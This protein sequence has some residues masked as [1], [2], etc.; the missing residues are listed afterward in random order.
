VLAL[1][2][3]IALVTGGSAGIGLASAQAL[4]ELGCSVIIAARHEGTLQQ[5]LTQLS[6]GAGQSHRMLRFDAANVSASKPELEDLLA[7]APISVLVNNSAGPAPGS[8]QQAQSA[9]FLQTFQQQL[10]GA[11]ELTQLLLPPMRAQ[12]FGRVI[13][14]IS[15]SVKEPLKDLGVSNTVRAAVAAWAKTL[16]AEVAADGVTIN[17]VL[18]GYTET[19][20]LTQIIAARVEKLGAPREA[21]VQAMLADVPIKRFAEPKEIAAAVA[22]LASPAAAYITGINIPVDGG[23]TRSL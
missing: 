22:F 15:T 23:R 16:A 17:N 9:Q 5:A 2:D 12:R 19:A 21:V 8:I 13:N 3:R 6:S 1:R 4:A 7:Q 14:I 10:L 11:H 18:P 20:R